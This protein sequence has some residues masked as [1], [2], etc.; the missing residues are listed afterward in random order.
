MPSLLSYD[1]AQGVYMY[2]MENRPP[3]LVGGILADVIWRI[4]IKRGTRKRE[5]L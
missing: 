5:K 4:N 3:S 2:I 1:H